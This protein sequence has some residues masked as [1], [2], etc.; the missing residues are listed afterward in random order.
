VY[1]SEQLPE[2]Q[3]LEKLIIHPNA[4]I[5][6]QSGSKRLLPSDG[7][8][9]ILR[10]K[11]TN[12]DYTDLFWALDK[13]YGNVDAAARLLA[14]GQIEE[15]PTH[16]RRCREALSRD[17]NEFHATLQEF[18]RNDPQGFDAL[19]V[20][21]KA[22]RMCFELG[23]NPAH[24]PIRNHP[25]VEKTP[26]TYLQRA[27]EIAPDLSDIVCKDIL[28]AARNEADARQQIREIQGK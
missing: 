20:D 13:T 1:G 17:P 14:N 25:S 24:F 27:R 21:E 22:E 8:L 11:T 18:A 4:V 7:R 5:I 26:S 10:E 6:V 16:Y 3:L 19:G 28:N 15:P 12:H 2:D 9:D 23:L